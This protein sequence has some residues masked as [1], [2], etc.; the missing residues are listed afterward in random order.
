MKIF[1][2]EEIKNQILTNIGSLHDGTLFSLLIIYEFG[3]NYP[4]KLKNLKLIIQKTYVALDKYFANS[5]VER[6]S[7]IEYFIKY[8]SS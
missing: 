7:L 8:I 5:G 4:E 2:W 3:I 6:K 1:K